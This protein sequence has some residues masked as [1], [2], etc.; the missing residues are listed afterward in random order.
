[1]RITFYLFWFHII[2]SIWSFIRINC[3]YFLANFSA[4]KRRCSAPSQFDFSTQKLKWKNVKYIRIFFLKYQY[5]FG[6]LFHAIVQDF[7][8]LLAQSIDEWVQ[9]DV[10][11][12]CWWHSNQ[13]CGRSFEL[14]GEPYGQ[15][16]QLD[17]ML[18]A[19]FA[20]QLTLFSCL[21]ISQMPIKCSM[22]C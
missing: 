6:I 12:F 21:F 16:S 9:I 1:M 8:L 17:A 4:S 20:R 18:F 22:V 5:S 15:F 11:D 3:D 13:K 7:G 14:Y 10:N 19:I 2:I